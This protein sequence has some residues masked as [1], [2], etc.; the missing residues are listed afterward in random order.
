M[1]A[2]AWYGLIL[3]GQSYVLGA[4]GLDA[5]VL[6]LTYGLGFLGVGVAVLGALARWF[7]RRLAAEWRAATM[8]TSALLAALAIAMREGGG[9][10]QRTDLWVA[11]LLG[12]GVAALASRGLPAGWRERWLGRA[13]ADGKYKGNSD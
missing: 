6:K 7:P 2:T 9:S 8:V 12:V 3:A 5:W 13:G 4:A 1:A 10:A 11:A